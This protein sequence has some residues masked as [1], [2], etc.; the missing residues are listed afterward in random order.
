M[1]NVLNFRPIQAVLKV[2]ER[3]PQPEKAH[4]PPKAGRHR[5]LNGPKGSV[6]EGISANTSIMP[7]APFGKRGIAEVVGGGTATHK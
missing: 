4:H 2:G 1:R 7:P 3:V 5:V 6:S